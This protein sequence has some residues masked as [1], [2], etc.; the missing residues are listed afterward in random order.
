M[1]TPIAL[2]LPETGF[3]RLSDIIGKPATNDNPGK[4][5]IIPVSASTWWSGVRSGRYPQPTRK[6][7]RR[8]TAWAVTDIRDL[9]E[10]ASSKAAE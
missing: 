7:G 5:A 1:R 4:P 3:L 8:V 6:L 10:A 2:T 9:I